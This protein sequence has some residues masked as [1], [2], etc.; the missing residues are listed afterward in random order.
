MN[1]LRLIFS[2]YIIKD[3]LDNIIYK[4]HLICINQC[5]NIFDYIDF[6]LCIDNIND[7]ETIEYVKQ[8][9]LNNLSNN[10]V[11]INFVI[12]QNDS[13]YREGNVYYNQL[14]LRIKEYADNNEL[15]LFTHT[16]G[17]TNYNLENS[18]NWICLIYYYCLYQF[19]YAKYC[20]IDP[21]INKISYGPLYHYSL[22]NLSKYKWMYTGGTSWLNTKHFYNY[23]NENNLELFNYSKESNI[24]VAAEEYLPNMLD[25][26]NV[27]FYEYEHFNLRNDII[28]YE[29]HMLCYDKILYFASLRMSSNSY[30][31]FLNYKHQIDNLIK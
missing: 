9:I 20:M 1:K 3:Q 29:S 17:L 19:W 15:V 31:D 21:S 30:Y 11:N 26:D 24:R 12:I 8:F 28:K 13:T 5:I 23:V 14:I 22:R 10:H 16:K 25:I 2:Y 18:I 27:S 4:Y 7:L 6:Y